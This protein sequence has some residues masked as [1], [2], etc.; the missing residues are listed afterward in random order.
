MNSKVIKDALASKTL[1]ELRRERSAAYNKY[2]RL[3]EQQ[4]AV[5]VYIQQVE[6]CMLKK[7]KETCKVH[8]C[9]QLVRGLYTDYCIDCD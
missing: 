6:D 1:A 8:T 9:Q 3:K 2:S 7:P 5:M 4:K